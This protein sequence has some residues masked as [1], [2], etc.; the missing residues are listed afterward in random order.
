MI[1]GIINNFKT[2]LFLIIAI[3]LLYIFIRYE[4]TR[5]V[6]SILLAVVFIFTGCLSIKQV[7]SYYTASGETYGSTA[8]LFNANDAKYEKLDEYTFSFK[9]LG[10]K[11]TGID[12]QYRSKIVDEKITVNLNNE[13][14]AIFINNTLLDKTKYNA[15]S[16]NAELTQQFNDTNSNKIIKD[17]LFVSIAFENNATELVLTTNGGD[18]A[19]GLWHS[20]LTKNNFILSIKK[21][22]FDLSNNDI[23]II[24]D[25]NFDKNKKDYNLLINKLDNAFNEGSFSL[26]N[27]EVGIT[28]NQLNN[29]VNN[30]TSYYSEQ[31]TLGYCIGQTAENDS[32]L[33]CYGYHP[34]YTNQYNDFDNY[35]DATLSMQNI[36]G[37]TIGIEKEHYYTIGCK[38]YNGYIDNLFA[39]NLDTGCLTMFKIFDYPD[40]FN[41]LDNLFN[42]QPTPG[43]DFHN[44]Q[45]VRYRTD[46]E[47]AQETDF[48]TLGILILKDNSKEFVTNMVNYLKRTL[49]QETSKLTTKHAVISID[50]SEYYNSFVFNKLTNQYV[51]N[52]APIN[53]TFQINNH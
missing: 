50:M 30:T 53:W 48:D 20:Y 4:A 40:W 41:N 3:L 14:W 6:I 26:S 9:K 15:N 38:L 52:S 32:V 45:T 21:V 28:I 43:S 39:E 7:F 47:H 12:N 8:S 22:N 17:T 34:T 31:I 29:L 18:I 44:S 46:Y 24:P 10:L 2:I 11:T 35:S 23:N 36:S 1:S 16:I 42:Y 33:H 51:L 27:D 13:T 37:Y 49:Q 5:I 25:E 19:V